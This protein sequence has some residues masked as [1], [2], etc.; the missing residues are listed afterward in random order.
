MRGGVVEASET[1]NCGPTYR[2][3]EEQLQP[4]TRRQLVVVFPMMECLLTSADL[5]TQ[6]EKTRKNGLDEE[7]GKFVFLLSRPNP[8]DGNALMIMCSES[9]DGGK[10]RKVVSVENYSRSVSGSGELLSNF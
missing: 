9:Q 10:P 4:D 1:V 8:A 3:K 2:I 7:G 5:Q 6:R